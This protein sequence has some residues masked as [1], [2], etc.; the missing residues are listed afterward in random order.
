MGD[1][2]SQLRKA[3]CCAQPGLSRLA[4]SGRAPFLERVRGLA[5]VPNPVFYFELPAAGEGLS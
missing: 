1:A 5:R 2:A 3:S 4:V